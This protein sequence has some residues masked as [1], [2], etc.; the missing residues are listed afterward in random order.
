MAMEADPR[1]GYQAKCSNSKGSCG[2]APWFVAM[3]D[4]I[5]AEVE[6]RVTCYDPENACTHP[7]GCSCSA[8]DD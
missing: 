1:E 7:S 6:H 2:W 8:C 5:N 4:A 3:T